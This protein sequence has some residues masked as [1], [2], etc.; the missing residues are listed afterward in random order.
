MSQADRDW[1]REP[2]RRPEAWGHSRAAWAL[3][4]L[5]ALAWLLPGAAGRLR[6]DEALGLRP[7]E[8]PSQAWTLLT[9]AFLAPQGGTGIALACLATLWFFARDVERAVGT[10]AMLL[11]FAAGALT[12]GVAAAVLARV[13]GDPGILTG[14]HGATSA[15]AVRWAL[16]RGDDTSGVPAAIVAGLAVVLPPAARFLEADDR[17]AIAWAAGALAGWALEWVAAAL[18]DPRW[19]GSYDHRCPAHRPRSGPGPHQQQQASCMGAGGGRA[20]QARPGGVGGRL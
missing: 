15:L 6:L 4:A 1:Y 14:G 17:L 19:R 10:K 12:A 8:L 13:T 2:D 20:D 18:A 3:A 9:H 16:R 11:T 5:A 7:L